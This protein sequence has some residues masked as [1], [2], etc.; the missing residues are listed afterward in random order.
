MLLF[1][2]SMYLEAFAVYGEQGSCDSPDPRRIPRNPHL[3]ERNEL[4]AIASRFFNQ[5]T[6]LI[7]R[8][9]E[10]E[11]DGFMLG[12]GYLDDVGHDAQ[13]WERLKSKIASWQRLRS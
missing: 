9:L 8:G 2:S 5:A 4:C 12:D 13:T 11:P 3:R 7:D 1:R 10:V 6:R